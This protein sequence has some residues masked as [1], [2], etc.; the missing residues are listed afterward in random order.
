MQN[1]VFFNL[2][3]LAM[4]HKLYY[5]AQ[6]AAQSCGRLM[7]LRKH[8]AKPC[9]KH[10]FL[11]EAPRKPNH[12]ALRG[13]ARRP[14]ST[15]RRCGRVYMLQQTPL[16]LLSGCFRTNEVLG[17]VLT[18]GLSRAPLKSIKRTSQSVGFEG[19]PNLSRTPS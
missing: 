4:R 17:R 7:F 10:T 13:T 18:Q 1:I 9:R 5:V 15:I 16:L 6:T 3:R 14:G 2:R 11:H 19:Q 8:F 12:A